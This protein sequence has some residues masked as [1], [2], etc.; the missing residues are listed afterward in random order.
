MHTFFP[1]DEISIGKNFT[2]YLRKKLGNGSFG[3]IY[4]GINTTNKKLVAIKCEKIIN[5]NTQMLKNEAE[6]LLFL[7]GGE[8]IPKLYNYIKTSKYN[9]MIIDFLGPNLDQLY[10]LCKKEFSL[11]IIISLGIQMLERIE[12]MHSRHIIHRD[13][14]PENF[15]MGKGDKNSI[16]YICDLGLAKRFRDKKTGAHIPYKNGKEFI[17][18]ACYASIYS[19]LGIEQSRRDDLESLAYS[20]IY[21]SKGNLPWRGIKAK[22]KNEKLSKIL[23]IKMNIKNSQICGDLPEE[24]S[25]FLQYIKDLQFEQRPDYEYLKNL[26]IKMFKDKNGLKYDFSNILENSEYKS[27]NELYN[28]N[29]EDCDINFNMSKS[30]KSNSNND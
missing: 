14:K 6:I 5:P 29:I 25:T 24:F 22:N 13:I 21:L 23:S 2:I 8:G 19:H 30:I 11:N 1:P 18:T 7:Q 3:N 28:K 10:Q 12:Y 4:Q 15:L 27:N 16:V 17:G 26:L 20:L 9:F